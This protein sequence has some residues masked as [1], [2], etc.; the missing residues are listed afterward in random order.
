M[1]T[2]DVA[3]DGGGYGNSQGDVNRDENDGLVLMVNTRPV[4]M[5]MM[6]VM[7]RIR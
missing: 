3:R 6:Q 1:M 5:M 4:V 2:E 7:V